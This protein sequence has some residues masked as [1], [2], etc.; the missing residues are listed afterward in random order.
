[1]NKIKNFD[2]FVSK[3][4][5]YIKIVLLNEILRDVNWSIGPLMTPGPIGPLMTLDTSGH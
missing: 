5:I 2:Y 4:N 1:M 3:K